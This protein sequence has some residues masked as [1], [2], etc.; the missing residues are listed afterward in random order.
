MLHHRKNPCKLWIFNVYKGFVLSKNGSVCNF[1]GL[2]G[3]I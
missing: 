2:Y 1:M 3:L